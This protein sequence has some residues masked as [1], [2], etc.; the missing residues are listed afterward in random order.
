M[1]PFEKRRLGLKKSWVSYKGKTIPLDFE[2]R[3]G[4][5]LDCGKYGEHNQLHHEAYDDNDPLNHTV[6]LCQSCHGFRHRKAR[7]RYKRI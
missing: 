1:T 6:E 2:P 4:I 7:M 5:C 3:T